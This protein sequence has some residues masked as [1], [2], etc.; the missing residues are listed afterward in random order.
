MEQNNL[1]QTRKTVQAR[2][3]FFGWVS[4]IVSGT[5]LA[6]VG[7]GIANPSSAFAKLCARGATHTTK[8]SSEPGY[9][10]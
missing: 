10:G 4:K 1:Q 3:R 9:T 5:V 8:T 6:G 7:L 2:R